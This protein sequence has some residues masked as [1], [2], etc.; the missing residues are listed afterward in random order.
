M[1]PLYELDNIRHIYGRRTVIEIKRLQ[2]NPGEIVGIHGPNGSGKS[3]L[4]RVLGFIEAP[5][6]GQIF[7]EGKPAHPN[8]LR[9]SRRAT[10]LPQAPYL[11]KRSVLSNVAYGLK[12]RGISDKKK[13]AHE[14]LT[15]VGLDPGTFSGRMWYALSGGEAQQVALA[16]RLV[17]RPK[18]LLLDEPTAYLDENSSGKIRSAALFARQKWG[19][20]LILVSHDQAWLNSVCQRRL[21]MLRGRLQPSP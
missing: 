15:M 1:P 5:S 4:L 20:A 10:L 17:L 7:F 12:I 11:L 8:D 19:T 6:R 3:T 18:V 16:A 21:K 9:C 2:F 14:A 13:K